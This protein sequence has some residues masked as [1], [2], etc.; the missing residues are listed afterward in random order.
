MVVGVGTD[1]KYLSPQPRTMGGDAYHTKS[2]V[3]YLSIG[4]HIVP[5]YH[6]TAA[7]TFYSSDQ[8]T[9]QYSALVH[10]RRSPQLV[11][12]WYQNVIFLYPLTAHQGLIPA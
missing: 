11:L 7:Q 3:E 2:A 12:R 10:K 9:I 6:F 8:L 5:I 1:L 4:Q